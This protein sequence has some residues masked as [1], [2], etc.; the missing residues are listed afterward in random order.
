ML[1][2]GFCSCWGLGLKARK[3]DAELQL[4]VIVVRRETVTMKNTGSDTQS[5]F[6]LVCSAFCNPMR[7]PYTH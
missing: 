4:V 6:L 5:R 3:R 2:L 7:I 1:E